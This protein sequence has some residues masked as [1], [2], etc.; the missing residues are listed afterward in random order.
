MYIKDQLTKKLA[1]AREEKK[2]DVKASPNAYVLVAARACTLDSY[3]LLE[4]L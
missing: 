4:D 2:K 3:S 1:I